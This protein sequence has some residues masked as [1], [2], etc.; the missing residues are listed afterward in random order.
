MES[1]S[2]TRENIV[3]SRTLTKS[4][5]LHKQ[6]QNGAKKKKKYAG[7]KER[8][9]EGNHSVLA[10]LYSYLMLEHFV[11]FIS[12]LFFYAASICMCL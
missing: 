1:G 3:N 11:R 6:L 7:T 10:L 8:G 9:K 12:S 4:N 2:I 5:D